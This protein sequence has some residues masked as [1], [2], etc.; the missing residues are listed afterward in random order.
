MHIII[1]LQ[2][3]T[4]ILVKFD[5][6]ELKYILFH[7]TIILLSRHLVTYPKNEIILVIF[8]LQNFFIY[9]LQLSIIDIEVNV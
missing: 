7:I 3:V 6:F 4:I 5:C 2:H 1:R 8:L 9:L